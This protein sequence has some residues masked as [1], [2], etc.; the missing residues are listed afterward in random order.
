MKD[1]LVNILTKLP[2]R[3]IALLVVIIGGLYLTERNRN[4]NYAIKQDEIMQTVNKQSEVG[5][6]LLN[7]VG[8]VRGDIKDIKTNQQDFK[9]DLKIFELELKAITKVQSKEIKKEV[10][11]I[12]EVRRQTDTI[13]MLYSNNHTTLKYDIVGKINPVLTDSINKRSFIRR[14]GQLINRIL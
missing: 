7:E 6:V 4:K 8:E 10:E 12:Q 13:P 14:L 1:F 3:E 11:I 9:I 2:K 5:S